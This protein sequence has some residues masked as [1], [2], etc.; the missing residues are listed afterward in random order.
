MAKTREASEDD[1]I[2]IM[3]IVIG[4]VLVVVLGAVAGLVVGEL[5]R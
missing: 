1:S 4:S 3:Q 5:L 2:R